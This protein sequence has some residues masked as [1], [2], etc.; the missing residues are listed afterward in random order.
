MGSNFHS[1]DEG[2]RDYLI[3]K[4]LISERANSDTVVRPNEILQAKLDY[5][6]LKVDSKQL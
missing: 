1:L 3:F 2:L 6:S 4:G 5:L